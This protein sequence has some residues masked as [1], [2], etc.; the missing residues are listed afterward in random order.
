M[1]VVNLPNKDRTKEILTESY[2]ACID[3]LKWDRIGTTMR[4]LKWTWMGASESPSIRE[5]KLLCDSLFSECLNSEHLKQGMDTYCSSG[6]FRVEANPRTGFVRVA[7][8]L[9]SWTAR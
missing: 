6:G 5:M 3:N 7:F 8:E 4:M 9:D 2:N 1:T